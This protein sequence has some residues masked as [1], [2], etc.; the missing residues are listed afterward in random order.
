MLRLGVRGAQLR[1]LVV[2]ALCSVGSGP[3]TGREIRCVSC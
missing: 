3:G 1:L 2:G